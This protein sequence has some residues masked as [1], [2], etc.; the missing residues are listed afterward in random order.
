MKLEEAEQALQEA[1]RGRE[2]TVCVHPPKSDHVFGTT[3]CD[4]THRLID[5]RKQ[6]ERTKLLAQL[7]THQQTSVDLKIELE[8]YGAADPI[9]MEIKRS[10]IATAKEA[11][12]LWTGT[13]F[14]VLSL[15]TMSRRVPG[16]TLI[17]NH[18][19]TQITLRFCT[20]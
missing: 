20:N 18:W 12:L 14:S 3:S 6:E 7:A 19:G 2:D 5:R 16:W 17:R 13:S 15:M 8:A 9:K 10:A 4:R 11:C 1:T